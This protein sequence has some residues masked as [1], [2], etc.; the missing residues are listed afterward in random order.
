MVGGVHAGVVGRAEEVG[1]GVANRPAQQGAEDEVGGLVHGGWLP[2]HEAQAGSAGSGPG[3][4]GSLGQITT[5][6]VYHGCG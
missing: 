1:D 5:M 2:V 6:Q 3:L 4:C